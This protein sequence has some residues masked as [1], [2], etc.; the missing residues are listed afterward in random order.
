MDDRANQNG[1]TMS[2]S[3]EPFES[4]E[5]LS[6]SHPSNG[7]PALIFPYRLQC[8]ACGFEPADAITAPQRCIKCNRSAFERFPLPKSLLKSSD[9]RSKAFIY[10]APAGNALSK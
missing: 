8:R 10:A 3:M 1:D 2:I 7:L 9:Q 6:Q 4:H 5:Q